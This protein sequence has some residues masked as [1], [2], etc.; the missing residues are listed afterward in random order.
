M[1]FK[2]LQGVPRAKQAVKKKQ[3]QIE[4]DSQFLHLQRPSSQR[5]NSCRPLIARVQM[6]Q[7]QAQ[8]QAELK[9]HVKCG[10]IDDLKIAQDVASTFSGG[11][12]CSIQ[13]SA[14]ELALSFQ[15]QQL[16]ERFTQRK[17]AKHGLQFS[18]HMQQ[19]KQF[20]SCFEMFYEE[21]HSQREKESRLHGV[22]NV[23]QTED[24]QSKSSSEKFKTMNR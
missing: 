11:S 2:L 3:D 12:C 4:N 19:T 6:S 15:F 21:G 24:V 9:K 7:L 10:I 18:Q 23:L 22:A 14:T 1:E 8:F 16:E 5:L 13:L 20:R 17:L